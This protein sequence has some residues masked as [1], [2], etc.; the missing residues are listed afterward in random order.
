MD[1]RSSSF[2]EVHICVIFYFSSIG[3]RLGARSW[4]EALVQKLAVERAS[5]RSDRSEKRA[6]A[7]QRAE[8][9]QKASELSDRR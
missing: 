2:H 4:L 1:V 9:A 7:R 5:E 3:D 8:R 6:A